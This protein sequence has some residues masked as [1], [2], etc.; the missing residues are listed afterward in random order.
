[1]HWPRKYPTNL[2]NHRVEI[3]DTRVMWCSGDTVVKRFRNDRDRVKVVLADST[4]FYTIFDACD[5]KI[6]DVGEVRFY[7]GLVVVAIERGER[8][9]SYL[10]SEPLD[11]AAMWACVHG[12]FERGV[13]Y[14]DSKPN[15]FATIRGTLRFIDIEATDGF[16][17]PVHTTC[18]CTRAMC[19]LNVLVM[20]CYCVH[21]L[22]APND[23]HALG[24]ILSYIRSLELT[25][26]DYDNAF[27]S[28]TRDLD[29]LY[30]VTFLRLFW[31]DAGETKT[32]PF[33]VRHMVYRLYGQTV[34]FV[35]VF[36]AVLDFIKENENDA[37][38]GAFDFRRVN[39]EC[40]ENTYADGTQRICTK[41]GTVPPMNVWSVY[42]VSD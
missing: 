40:I 11:M 17:D 37:V 3:G 42:F 13:V 29:F 12:A 27:A 22:C 14:A 8:F 23:A 32:K 9:Y 20:S 38:L 34:D 36:R 15:N 5:V 30:M 31:C 35:D 1:M 41:V 18:P 10:V 26:A 7:D 24:S 19:A 2:V 33:P 25:D 4:H 39:Y 28:K 6:D 21:D 16:V